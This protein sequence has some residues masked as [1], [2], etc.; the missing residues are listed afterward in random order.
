MSAFVHTRALVKQALEDITGARCPTRRAHR[1]AEV[2]FAIWRG[3][4]DAAIW[5]V[6]D[7]TAREAIRRVMAEVTR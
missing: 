2:L 6:V 5:P 1:L 7:P 4:E 3:E